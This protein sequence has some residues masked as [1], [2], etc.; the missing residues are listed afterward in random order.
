MTT[1]TKVIGLYIR[2]STGKQVEHGFS[3]DAQREEGTQFAHRILSE[4]ITIECYVDEGISAKST[5]GRHALNKIIKD[6]VSGKLDAIITYKVS[7]L[8]RSLSDSLKLVEEIHRERVRFISIKEGEYGTPHGNLQFNILASVA[9]YQREELAENVQLGMSQRARSGKFN[10]GIVLGY[11]TVDKE[12]IVIE[13]EAETVKLIFDKFANEGWGTKKISNYLNSI[14]KRTKKGKTFAVVSAST[15]LDNP[16]YKGYVRFN[17]VLNWETNRRKG[18]N[19][20]PIIA[21]GTHEPIIDEETWSKASELREKRRT[22]TPRQYSGTF[23][24][25][26]IAKCPECGAYMTSLYGSKR[27]DGTKKRYYA[28][29]QYHNKGRSVCNPNLIDADWLE[30]AVFDRLTQTLQSDSA[31][32]RIT[33]QINQLIEQDPK[34]TEQTKEIKILESQLTKL[35]QQ[36]RRVQESVETGSGIHTEKEAAE[37]MKEIRAEISETKNRVFSLKEQPSKKESS[38]KPVTQSFIR[39]Q[40]QE[41]LE[42]KNYLEP[43]EFRQLIVASIEKIEAEKKSLEHIHFSF[44]ALLPEDELSNSIPSFTKSSIENYIIKSK[45]TTPLILKGLYFTPNCYLLM[46]RLPPP[47]P[48]APIN[49]LQQDQSH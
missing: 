10:G 21:K 20:N 25:T 2:V 39:Q 23:P 19:P 11:K 44:I 32:E 16:I 43:L 5:K 4:D 27:K 48:K 8:S 47:N 24:I 34:F 40:L 6:A 22:G 12:L 18:K 33:N 13:E 31:I 36:R 30:N 37:R 38:L 17:Q 14:G 7:R 9:Q 35:E 45:R 15:I 26:S 41:F 3:L 49:L 29:G 46:I 1:K 42:L 28:C